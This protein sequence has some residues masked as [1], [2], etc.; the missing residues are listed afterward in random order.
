MRQTVYFNNKYITLSIRC[1]LSTQILRFQPLAIEKIFHLDGNMRQKI[2]LRDVAEAAGVTPATVSDILNDRDRCWASDKTRE[3]VRAAALRLGYQ[4]NLAARMLRTGSS[5]LVGIVVS[6]LRNPFYVSLVREIQSFLD[7]AGYGVI[8]EDSRGEPKQ[9]ERALR[10]LQSLSV[11][12]MICATIFGN[13]Q[14]SFFREFKKTGKPLVFVGEPYS[15][16]K[17]QSV[18]LDDSGAFADLARLLREYGHQ[19]IAYISAQ[20]SALRYTDRE[21][22]FRSALNKEKLSLPAESVFNCSRQLRDVAECVNGICQLPAWKR[23]TIIFVIND[24]TAIA[25]IRS[26]LDSGLRVPEDVSVVGFDD[27]DLARWLPI[28][29]TTISQSYQEIARG[30]VKLLTEYNNPSAKSLKSISV[31]AELLVRDSLAT[32]GT[33]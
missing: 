23:P 8:I 1:G 17:V 27:I 3:R 12:G 10:N 32:A 5:R 2:T 4:V 29:L 26:L 20:S 9:E 13:S 33:L 24:F 6:D 16:L 11:D 30:C 19:R 18:Q 25:V 28:R 14:E 31:K 21:M 7:A 22:R 15:E